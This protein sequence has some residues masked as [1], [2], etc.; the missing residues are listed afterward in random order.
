VR[1]L[2]RILGIWALL[3]VAS[4]LGGGCAS[5]PEA[6]RDRDAEAKEF[7]THPNAGTIYVYRSE[8]DRLE[9]DAVLYMDGR[10]VGQTL[11]GAYFRVDTVPGRHVLS[12]SGID[13]GKITI[14][15]RPGGL[16]FVELHVIEGHSHFRLVPEPVGRQRIAQ[17]CVRYET[18]APG[19][20]PLLK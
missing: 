6:P 13:T 11:P 19:Q 16:Y 10:I 5:T 4:V 20:R 14:D 9:D 7:R 3:L 2:E 8:H 15:T 1:S 17:C 18:W 12:G